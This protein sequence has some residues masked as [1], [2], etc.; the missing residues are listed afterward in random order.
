MKKLV[1]ALAP[2]ALVASMAFAQKTTTTATTTPTK[3]AA[4]PTVCAVAALNVN[5]AS[6][7]D[8]AKIPGINASLA[9]AIVKARPFTDEKDLV[10]KV[11]GIGKKNIIQFR[12]CFLY[13]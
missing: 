10:K 7:A 2:L 11:K 5:T 6:A 13:K 3:A 8:L 12:S 4:V 1:I 9:D